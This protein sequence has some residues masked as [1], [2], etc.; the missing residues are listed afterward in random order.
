MVHIK[1]VEIFGFKSFGFKNTTVNFRPGL[2]TISGPNGSGKSNILNAI[3][4]ALGE[5][6]PRIMG[7]D[8]LRSLVHEVGGTHRGVKMTRASVHFDN[9]DR[10]IPVN[11]DT[12]EITREMDA[13][14]DNTYYVNKK[15]TQRTNVLNLLDTANAGLGQLNALQQGTV[16]RISEFSPEEK[17]VAIEDLV[18]LSFFDERKSES[19]KQLTDAD[20]RLELALTKMDEV[21][22]RIDELEETRNLYLRHKA[23]EGQITR[24]NAIDAARGLKVAAQKIE[25]KTTQSDELASKMREKRQEIDVLRT[26]LTEVGAEKKEIVDN[27]DSYNQAKAEI[28]FKL[29]DLV[30]KENIAGASVAVAR[31]RLSEIESR[32]PQAEHELRMVNEEYENHQANFS[33]LKLQLDK[34]IELKEDNKTRREANG[35]ELARL[36]RQNSEIESGRKSARDAIKQLTAQKTQEVGKL[37]GLES[38]LN[39]S[40]ARFASNHSKI[41][42]INASIG[43]LNSTRT[44]LERL[45]VDHKRSAVS[46]KSYM[47]RLVSRRA[48]IQ[49]E[50]DELD[51]ILAKSQN[52]TSQ[53]KAKLKM[54]RDIM[55]EDYSIAQLKEHAQKIGI[56]GFAYEMLDWDKGYERAALAAGSEWLKAIVTKD[57]ATMISLSEYVRSKSLPKVKIISLQNAAAPKETDVGLNMLVSH[58]RSKPEHTSL[59]RFVFGDVVLAK[60]SQDARALAQKGHRAVTLDGELVEPGASA[61]I[62]DTNSKISRLTRVIAN[63]ATLEGLVQSISLLKKYLGKKRTVSQRADLA[64]EKARQRLSRTESSISTSEGE[65]E[66]L[67]TSLQSAQTRVKRLEEQNQMIAQRK[68]YVQKT[69][70]EIKSKIHALDTNIAT[71]ESAM[72]GSEDPVVLKERQRLEELRISLESEGHT[73]LSEYSDI[74]AKYSDAKGERSQEEQNKKR[75][76]TEIERL[77]TEKTELDQNILE[78]SASKQALTSQVSE[79]RGQEHELISTRGSSAGQITEYDERLED[80]RSKERRVDKDLNLDV[81]TDDQLRRDLTELRARETALKRMCATFDPNKVDTDTDVKALLGAL[82]AEHEAITNLNTLAPERYVEISD[83]YRTMSDKKNTLELERNKIIKLIEDVEKDKRQTFLEAFSVVDAEVKKVFSKMTGGNA[84]LELEDEDDIFNTGISYVIQ[85]PTKPK[86]ESS[87]ISGGEKSIA[88]IV[89][90]LALQ[91]LNP[92]P[93]YLFDEVDAHLD[94]PNSEKLA[95]ILKERAQDSQFI[96]ISLKDTLVKKADLTYGVYPKNGV[97]QVLL[98]KDKQVPEISS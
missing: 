83:S 59:A 6:K 95:N 61:I 19:E 93:F 72:R 81:R 37:S 74:S 25:E 16:T 24:L 84:Y 23:L 53:Y 42:A 86:R 44:R 18:G 29:S 1:K 34:T 64:L 58:I 90:V 17:R 20:H 71:S 36:I 5:N 63:A 39:S 7:V 26:Q 91:K 22:K 55:H 30:E 78:F 96:L 40:E 67:A 31:R 76:E 80:L 70:E 3:I 10:K 66:N 41:N 52:A 88:A 92:S 65:R 4:F 79:A 11:S 43:I 94:A 82:R 8:K 57:T 28:E 89:F 21:K 33:A 27:E 54:I 77:S 97:S 68:D 38:E 13:K 12:V 46:T 73:I 50:I 15:K 2:V 35:S 62:L 47:D 69:I 49:K 9:I 45:I 48:H 98:Y 87:A 75:I 56:E 32:I 14:G 85:F 51:E 60:S